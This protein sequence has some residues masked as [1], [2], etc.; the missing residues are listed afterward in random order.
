M[1]V[2][3]AFTRFSSPFYALFVLKFSVAHEWCRL[4]FLSPVARCS[5]EAFIIVEKRALVAGVTILVRLKHM[6]IVVQTHAPPD[7]I[8]TL[9][10]RQKSAGERL[11]IER[12][13]L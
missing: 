5:R 6:S 12:A 8:A 9:E 11:Q 1:I 2:Y 4:F 3:F 10:G 13:S 7:T